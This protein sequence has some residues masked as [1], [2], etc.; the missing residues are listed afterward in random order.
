MEIGLKILDKKKSCPFVDSF[1]GRNIICSYI[2]H[3]MMY[4]Y[5]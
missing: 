3:Y 5:K 4:I 2:K 1:I